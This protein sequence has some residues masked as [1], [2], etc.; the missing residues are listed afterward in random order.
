MSSPKNGSNC[1]IEKKEISKGLNCSYYYV[2]ESIPIGVAVMDCEGNCHQ[3]NS[4]LCKIMGFLNQNHF[5]Q[6]LRN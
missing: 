1:C 5:E 3:V 4:E 2:Y 6:G